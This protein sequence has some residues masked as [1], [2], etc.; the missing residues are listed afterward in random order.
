M[1]KYE[2]KYMIFAEVRKKPKTSVWEVLNRKGLYSLGGIEWYSPWR[3]YVYI[4]N[5]G[6][7]YNNSCLTEIA[8]FLTKLNKEQKEK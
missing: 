8:E 4:P 2:T 3:Q 6:T 7:E 1:R 5:P